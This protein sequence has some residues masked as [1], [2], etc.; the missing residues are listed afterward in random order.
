MANKARSK[1]A[2]AYYSMYK[3]SK[4]EET[5][6]RKRL[7]RELK[8]NPNNA[9]QIELAIKN[10]RHRRSTPVTPFWNSTRRETARLFK[11]FTGKVPVELFSS[12]D[13]TSAVAAMLAGPYSTNRKYQTMSENDMFKLKNIAHDKW[14]NY[15]WM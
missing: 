4:R 2:E 5:N 10:I 11:L 13:R 15:V 3:T 14:G 7:E 12:S 9:K 8:R 6:R 1:S